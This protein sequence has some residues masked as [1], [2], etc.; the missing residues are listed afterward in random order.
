MSKLL[1]FKAQFI[2]RIGDEIGSRG[3]YFGSV[4][5]KISIRLTFVIQVGFNEASLVKGT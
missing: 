4:F 5:E 3:N 2:P 1:Q